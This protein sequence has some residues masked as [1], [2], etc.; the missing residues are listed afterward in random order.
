MTMNPQVI[1]SDQ[2]KIYRGQ[3]AVTTEEVAGHILTAMAREG[4][5]QIHV[6]PSEEVLAKAGITAR[7]Y[8]LLYTALPS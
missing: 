8:L 1:I 2:L 3:S 6:A 7:Q 4:W 5:K